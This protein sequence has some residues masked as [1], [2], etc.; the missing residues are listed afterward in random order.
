MQ[1]WD[2]AGQERFRTIT[3]GYYRSAHGAMITYD[4][5]RP[6]TFESLS[7]WI[8][9]VEQY[10]AASIVVIFIGKANFIKALTS[11]I[12]WGFSQCYGFP[13]VC[14]HFLIQSNVNSGNRH[15]GLGW[16][17]VVLAV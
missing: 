5:T 10:G 2:T 11:Q 16:L 4:L 6:S 12:C 8:Q 13:I 1:V 9:E 17:H 3:Q 15:C 14:F 7:H